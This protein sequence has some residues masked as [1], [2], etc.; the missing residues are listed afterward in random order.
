M[1]CPK[2]GAVLPQGAQVCPICNEPAFGYY[3]QPQGA[4]YPPYNQ[5]YPQAQPGQ[6]PA[7]PVQP[8]YPQP[9]Q[10]P[11]QPAQPTYPQGYQQ[12]QGYNYPQGYQQPQ[13]YGYPQQPYPTYAQPPKPRGAFV[14][15]LTYLPRV[16]TGAFRD[17]GNILQGLMER[18]DFYT[19]A[20][21]A[22][23]SL[24]L[25]FLS[26][27]VVTRGVIALL[28]SGISA[29]TGAA[30][31]GD[32]ASMSQGVSYIAG[33]VAPSVGGNAVLCQ[34][35][36]MLIPAGVSMVYLCAVRKLRFTWSLLSGFVAITTL[37]T[38]AVSLLSM[39]LS[40]ITP[41]L[42]LACVVVGQLVSSVL[43]CALLA[44]ATGKPDAELVRVKILVLGISAL[45]TFIFVALVGGS[46]LGT[47]FTRISSMFG[48]M[49][50]LL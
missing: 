35:F 2:C 48:S 14:N 25:T 38:V 7:Q 16:V 10:A 36:A 31:A 28:F 50:S 19:G 27:M 8:T 1:N 46:L 47:T 44:R 17:P 3:Q 37:P 41:L 24:L 18:D 45:L 42:A 21:I 20:V 22:G 34:L 39:L 13:G 43:L 11:Q 29:V 12:P 6:A 49:G 32:A 23:L 26:A 15:A 9:A 4:A 40:L 33:K 5:P 30:L